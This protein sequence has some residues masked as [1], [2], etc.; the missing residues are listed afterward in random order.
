MRPRPILRLE[1]K[2]EGERALLESIGRLPERRLGILAAVAA[3]AVLALFASVPRPTGAAAPEAAETPSGTWTTVVREM[4]LPP[5]PSLQPV[6]TPHPRGA[7][8]PTPI[9]LDVFRL[10]EPLPEPAFL[11]PAAA[12]EPETL[13]GTPEPPPPE[14]PTPSGEPAVGTVPPRPAPGGKVAP[15]YPVAARSL[16][17]SGKVEL[18][19]D[20]DAEGGVT[21]VRV[22]QT[23]RPGVGFEDAATRAVERWRF[24]PATRGAVPVSGRTVVEV[25]F[26]W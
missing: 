20:V 6:A 15:N 24:V 19:V 18:E 16:R 22:V 9:S 1:D 23:D 8:A 21:A 3:T 25:V 5:A 2:I 7:V 10:P 12:G 17:L 11:P 26:R 4:P 14:A 13:L